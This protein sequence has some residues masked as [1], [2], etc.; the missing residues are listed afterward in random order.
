MSDF[1]KYRLE[2]TSDW[3]IF[4]LVDIGGERKICII[5]LFQKEI[6]SSVLKIRLCFLRILDLQER[7][8]D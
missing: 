8:L 5:K 2:C 6:F 4:L 1:Y 3:Y 7:S